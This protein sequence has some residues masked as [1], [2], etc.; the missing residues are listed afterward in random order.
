MFVL[1]EAEIQIRVVRKGDF[2]Y[3]DID[4][5]CVLKKELNSLTVGSVKSRWA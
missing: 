5:S 4:V 1:L 2:C 3:K